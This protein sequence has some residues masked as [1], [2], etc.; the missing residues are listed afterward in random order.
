M[1]RILTTI[2]LLSALA[3][4]TFA[5]NGKAI[6]NKYSDRQ[7]VSAVYI[8]PAVFKM[9]KKLPDI[10]TT[11]GDINLT[12]M[13][14]SL[15][16]FYLLS[17]QHKATGSY[18]KADVDKALK[19]GKYE[20]LLEAKEDRENV[21]IYTVSKDEIVTSLA[22]VTTDD[23]SVTFICLDGKIPE[24]ALEKLLQASL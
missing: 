20:L 13:I 16:G 3:T 1:K 6:Y 8:S 10:N 23:S 22:I 15:T 19:E 7:E 2:V 17:T 9:M 24:S 4:A 18:I 14:E 11:A 12:P 21:R 5:Q